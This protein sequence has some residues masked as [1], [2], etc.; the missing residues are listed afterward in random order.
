MEGKR[1][2]IVLHDVWD[3]EVL[4]HLKSCLPEVGKGIFQI[5][6]TTRD[7]GFTKCISLSTLGLHVEVVR[8]LNVK[9]SKDLLREK[10]FGHQLE[11]AAE[12]IAKNCEGLP[13]MIVTVANLLSK[14]EKTLEYWNEVAEKRNSLFVDAY[15]AILEVLLSYNYLPHHLKMFFLYIYGSFPSRLQ[16]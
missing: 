8:F 1:C 7:R 6:V 11:N 16:N 15:N 5:L 12:K 13:L 3:E 2:L 14:A 10:V 4:D 9:E